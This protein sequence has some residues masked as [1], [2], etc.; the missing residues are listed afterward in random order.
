MQIKNFHFNFVLTL[1]KIFMR[2]INFC[3]LLTLLLFFNENH[4]QEIKSSTISSIGGS[5]TFYVGSKR[6]YAL[7]S[8]GQES[9]IGHF[10]N[11]KLS[12]RQGYI[13]PP[14]NGIYKEINN[15]KL[16]FSVFPNPFSDDLHI[17]N[18]KDSDEL[19]EIKIEIFDI[20]GRVVHAEIKTSLNDFKLNLSHLQSAS[21]SLKLTAGNYQYSYKIIKK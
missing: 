2:Q 14:I 10:F 12:V 3:I 15:N 18:L 21:Y 7:Y 17:K 9:V 8:I 20:L 5:T 16:S 19:F 1:I 6:Y 11:N 4:S 13:Q